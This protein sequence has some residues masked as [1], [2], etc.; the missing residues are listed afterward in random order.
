MGIKIAEFD[1]ELKTV[2]TCKKFVGKSFCQ[3]SEGTFITEGKSY[4]SIAKPFS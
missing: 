4:R 3:K 2:E 1:A